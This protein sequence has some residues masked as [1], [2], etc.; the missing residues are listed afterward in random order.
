MTESTEN[1]IA[2]SVLIRSMNNTDLAWFV[3]IM[4]S[5]ATIYY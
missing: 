3:F 2:Y 4:H 1:K 5:K